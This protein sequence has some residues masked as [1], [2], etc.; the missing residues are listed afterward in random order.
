MYVCKF[1]YAVSECAANLGGA[2]SWTSAE[3]SPV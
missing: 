2:G 3:V 1:M